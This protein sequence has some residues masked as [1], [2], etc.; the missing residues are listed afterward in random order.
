MAWLTEK[1]DRDDFEI[2]A[3]DEEDMKSN[4]KGGFRAFFDREGQNMS[5]CFNSTLYVKNPQELNGTDLTCDAFRFNESTL[6]SKNSSTT[7]CII[8]TDIK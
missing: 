4:E 8:G 1:T 3:T 6:V 7:L 2:S 5:Y